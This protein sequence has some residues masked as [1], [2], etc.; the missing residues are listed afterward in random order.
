MKKILITLMSL[1]SFNVFGQSYDE[2]RPIWDQYKTLF[3]TTYKDVSCN[4]DK[5]KSMD[6]NR[7]FELDFLRN[8][9]RYLG[10]F[11]LKYEFLG[12]S[13]NPKDPNYTKKVIN[14]ISMRGGSLQLFN[15]QKT[16]LTGKPEFIV[17]ESQVG[18]IAVSKS[19]ITTIT[20][21]SECY[22]K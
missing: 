5:C 17:V 10:K 21:Y 1:I 16:N 19:E 20:Y 8:E 7:S 6:V 3:C 4:L 12:K 15:F 13:F 11:D 22:P 2:N 9:L 18:P 14:T